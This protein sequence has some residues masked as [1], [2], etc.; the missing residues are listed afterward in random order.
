MRVLI[1]SRGYVNTH[2]AVGSDTEDSFPIAMNALVEL[3]SCKVIGEIPAFPYSLVLQA[4]FALS[5]I[6]RALLGISSLRLHRG[7]VQNI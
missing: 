4:L 5:G 6:Q 3:H 1:N 2:S 7:H